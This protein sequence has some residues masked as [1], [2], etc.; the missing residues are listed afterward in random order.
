MR[1]SF[2]IVLFICC[3][4]YKDISA[5]TIELETITILDGKA[6]I[7]IPKGFTLMTEEM[8][9]LK[10]PG[11]NPPA[12]VYT[13]EEGNVNVAFNLTES[14]AAQAVLPEY[15]KVFVAKF[16]EVHPEAEWK[17]NGIRSIN[18]QNLG[19][20]ELVTA[21]IDSKIYNLLFFTDVDGKLLICTFNAVTRL[22]DTWKEPAQEIF[23]SLKIKK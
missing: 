15:L 11:Q 10:Y 22:L 7:R 18:G 17:G 21:A 23:K 19:Y 16:K 6:E 5:Q 14:T 13:N 8:K 20:L 4:S 12:V 2:Y 1:R 9:K 3:I